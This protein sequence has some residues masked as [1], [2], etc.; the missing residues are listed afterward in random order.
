MS[1]VDAAVHLQVCV[2]VHL[3]LQNQINHLLHVSTAWASATQ[4]DLVF[5]T[6]DARISPA[7]VADAIE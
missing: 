7:C 2:V 1:Q 6:V 4:R 3:V 5:D